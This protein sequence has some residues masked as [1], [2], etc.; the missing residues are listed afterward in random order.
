[1]HVKPEEEA[2]LTRTVSPPSQATRSLPATAHG[3]DGRALSS[4][5]FENPRL[6]AD[7]KVDV[8]EGDVFLTTE[9]RH[10]VVDGRTAVDILPFLDGTYG[11]AEIAENLA[12]THTLGDVLATVGRYGALGHLVEGPAGADRAAAAWWDQLN[13]GDLAARTRLARQ[14]VAVRGVGHRA[15]EAAS[16]VAASIS[17]A[18]IH[19]DGLDKRDGT[20][21]PD[22]DVGTSLV[23]G[24]HD[25]LVVIADDYLN[26]ALADWNR[27]RL[28]LGGRWL[29]S[30]VTG[31][32]LWLGPLFVPGET[33]C[34]ECLAQRLRA[35]RQVERY[36]QN[37]TRSG[38]SNPGVPV[39]LPTTL[40]AASGLV[41]TEAMRIAAA[42]TSETVAGTL[43]TID[44]TTL[45]SDR[46]PLV[47]Q[48]QCQ[49]CGD[50]ELG[51]R[52]DP[53][54]LTSQRRVFGEDGGHR[55][56][57]PAQ[58]VEHL[59]RQVSSLIGAISH[60]DRLTD[61]HD[62]VSHAYSAGH[63]FALMS[64]SVHTLRRNVRGVSGGKGRT[65]VQARASAM[66]EAIERYAGVW[67]GNEPTV[68]GSLRELGERAL[69]PEDLLGFSVTQYAD[70]HR[71]NGRQRSGRHMVPERFDPDRRISWTQVWSLTNQHP[72]YAPTAYCYFGHPDL[73]EHSFCYSDANGNAA[74]NNLEEAILQGL[75]ELVERDS[76]A[77]WWYNRSRVPGVD[78]RSLDGGYAQ[79]LESY[80][81]EM[82]RDL[83]LLDITSD[84]GIPSFA[85]VSRCLD[86]PV[87]D[88]LLGFGAHVEP[89]LAA[90]RALTEC[91][92]FLPAVV[93]R[94]ADGQ[95]L[96]R[97]D[98]DEA[99]GWWRETTLASEPYL[100]A[101]PD[102]PHTDLQRMLD[103]SSDD[104]ADEIRT[105]VARLG[106]AGI[107]VLVLD[108]SR[109]DLD[110][111]VAKVMAPGL[112]HFWR[113]L[114]PGRLYDVPVEL[115]RHGA[116]LTE[117]DL[118]P[119]GVFF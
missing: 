92:Q 41:A 78:L 44:L 64:S 52:L 68:S 16:A 21:R 26:P 54:I 40:Q 70:R 67:Q 17:R 80:Y 117:S 83:R 97:F 88:I 60:L 112:R 38:W 33:G 4:F 23:G 56:T 95:T 102:Q 43:V 100:V 90:L 93:E 14:N 103:L 85:A 37:A 11:V 65:D 45:T 98:D 42:G 99:R 28:T 35:N 118:N 119:R 82:G 76:V 106:S 50:P 36:I 94:D 30:R 8:V 74:G 12:A 5:V 79:I 46:H 111:N 39:M 25:M 89:R 115:G 34:W 53:V 72:R 18:Y 19:H 13:I 71:W 113:R 91:N 104:L 84:L 24:E 114:G 27:D 81:A 20:G 57:T 63:N 109:P 96:Y 75:L 87:E 61:P 1:M 2:S 105:C 9:G 49:A 47:R 3:T 51:R 55:V 32:Q 69:N 101:A 110:I 86:H 31:S 6:K 108:Q 7:R 66:C 15:E 107:E 22:G 62:E 10:F 29:L 73:L 59:S 116:A 58:T 77:I 48:P